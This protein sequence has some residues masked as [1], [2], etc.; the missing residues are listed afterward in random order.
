MLIYRTVKRTTT[1]SKKIFRTRFTNSIESDDEFGNLLLDCALEINDKSKQ[2]IHLSS[3]KSK[4]LKRI[5]KDTKS[6]FKKIIKS[7]STSIN[8]EKNSVTHRVRKIKS[9]IENVLIKNL[10][11]NI[12]NKKK[13]RVN[14]TRE[15]IITRAFSSMMKSKEIANNNQNKLTSISKRDQENKQNEDCSRSRSPLERDTVRYKERKISSGIV[16]DVLKESLSLDDEKNCLGSTNNK[17]QKNTKNISDIFKLKKT[18]YKRR[19]KR[20]CNSIKNHNIITSD[21]DSIEIE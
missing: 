6:K 10:S 3:N 7:K 1:P 20:K 11:K 8:K 14:E 15:R 12:I 9:N 13:S 16:S 5:N 17:I 2:T 19:R 21:E 18:I 4:Q